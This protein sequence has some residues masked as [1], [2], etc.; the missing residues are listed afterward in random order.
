MGLWKSPPTPLGKGGGRWGNPPRPPFGRG[1]EEMG[2]PPQPSFGRGEEGGG[3]SLP[4]KGGS[5]LL[6]I[7]AYLVMG[8]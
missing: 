4:W 5:F 1:E 3:K 7:F 2:N 8:G 6:N